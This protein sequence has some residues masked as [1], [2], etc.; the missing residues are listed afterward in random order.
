MNKL[1]KEFIGEKVEI[2]ESK[3]KSLVGLKRTIIDETKYTFK[4]KTKDKVK[5]VMKN[6][7][8]FKIGEDLIQGKEITKKPHERIKLKVKNER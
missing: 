3:N 8:V 5:T 4:I 6:I 7:S 1:K 2:K